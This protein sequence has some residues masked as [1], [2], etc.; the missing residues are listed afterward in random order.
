MTK[1][2][3]YR[4]IVHILAHEGAAVER[5]SPPGGS[6]AVCWPGP[7]IFEPSNL[8]VPELEAEGRKSEADIQETEIKPVRWGQ[9]VTLLPLAW[10]VTAV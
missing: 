1:L 8:C 6:R 3:R 7:Q 5:S 4:H 2:L 9:K 10:I